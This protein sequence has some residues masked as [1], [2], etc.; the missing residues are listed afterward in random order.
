MF[1]NALASTVLLSLLMMPSAPAAEKATVLIIPHTHWEGAVFKTREEYLEMGLPHILKALTLLKRYPE[2]RFVLDQVAYVKPFLERYPAEAETFRKFVSEG[3][4]QIAGATNTMNDNNMPS[5][6]SIVR[7]FLLGKTYYHDKLGVDVKTGW[8][9][10]TFGHNA[11]MPQLLKLAGFG[12]YWF[13]RGVPGKDTPSEFLWRGIDGT[14]IP[15][16][17]LPL[18][19]APFHNIPR[20]KEEFESFA[21]RLYSQLGPFTKHADRMLMAGADVWEPEEHLPA[22]IAQFNETT[23]SGLRLKLAVP[24]DYEALVAKRTDRPVIGGE[25]NPVFQGIYSSRIELKQTMRDLERILTSAEKAAVLASRLGH[26]PRADEITRAWEPVL[27]N[28][29]HDLASGVMVDKVYEDTLA[30]YSEARRRGEEVLTSHL[31]SI[32]A[33]IDTRGDGVP[34]V[35]FNLLGWQRDDIVETDVY[36]SDSGIRRIGVLDPDGK[37]VPVQIVRQ[38]K[39]DNG[40]IRQARIAFIARGVPSMGHAVYRAVSNPDPASGPE[41]PSFGSD[42]DTRYTDTGTMENEFYRV[43]FNLW[44]GAITSLVLK[45]NNWEVLSAPANVVAREKDGGD[46]WELYGT[47]NGA[48]FTAMK[49]EVPAPAPESAEFTSANVGGGGSVRHGPVYS[50]FRITHPFGKNFFSTSVRLYNGVRRID[51]STQLVNNEEFVRYRVLFPTSLRKATNTQEI[52]F[53][54]IERPERAE[55]PAQNW[56]DYG[57]DTHGLTLLNRGLPGSNVADG[58]MMISLMR[59]AKLISYGYIGGYEPGVGS[60]TGLEV[61]KRL[62]FHYA[63][64]PHT[65]SWRA[66][67]AYQSGLEFNN[68]LVALTAARHPGPVPARWGLVA[69]SAP[70]VVISAMKP[71][72]RG[73]GAVVRVYEASGQPAAKVRLSFAPGVT[74][75]KEVN[76]T[77]NEIAAIGAGGNGFSFDLHPYEI[78]TF[79]VQIPGSANTSTVPQR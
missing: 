64:V 71:G 60:D 63:A 68:P 14:Q 16:F 62:A 33:S 66:S 15:A 75:A 41:S 37:A 72:V 40:D 38:E 26:D 6:E 12:S 9:L 42:S 39:N 29:A 54:A 19:Y 31:R 78:K 65:G 76:L 25:L 21:T 1:R 52:A 35:V 67:R 24:S 11:Q 61:G 7:Q 30:G 47:L 8:G 18:S 23:S 50:E 59:S 73:K 46:F 36:F 56:I 74:S 51:I 58:T 32:A 69:T 22:M 44:N 55:L 13:Q 10:D 27:F 57:D 43:G 49:R 20:G 53:G 28:Q 4:L 2:Y 17:W 3:R 77:E 70:N 34:V 48:R 45:E 5:G 79:E